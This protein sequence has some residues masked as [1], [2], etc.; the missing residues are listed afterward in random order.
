MNVT[1]PLHFIASREPK[2]PAVLTGRQALSYSRLDRT[3]W[4]GAAWFRSAGLASG[5]RVLLR[6]DNAL[7]L[8]IYPLEIENCLQEPPCVREAIAFPLIR[9]RTVQIPMAAVR[10]DGEAS[11]ADLLGH[12][13]DRLGPR[14]PRR[15][16][17]VDDF[18]RNAAGKP[19]KRKVA[20]RMNAV[21]ANA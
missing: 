18:P 12:C 21:I 11:E 5:D 19:L 20:E 16:A 6:V 9:G 17:I 8:N 3:L 13:R 4:S 10:L 2:R 7:L 14:C 1:L 15:V